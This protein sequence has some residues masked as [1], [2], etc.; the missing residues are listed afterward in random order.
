MK[1]G[2]YLFILLA[3]AAMSC[4]VAC[5][6]DDDEVES[7]SSSSDSTTSTDSDGNTVINGTTILSSSTAYGLV[8]NSS[9]GA[10]IAGVPVTDG[11]NFTTTDDN[12]VY[13]F[14]AYRLAR[15]I[16]ITVP[17]EYE[18]PL[19]SSTGLP[20]FY[21]S[22]SIS[23]SGFRS[24]F[25]LTPLSGG[26]EDEFTLVMIGDPQCQSDS[27]VTRWTTETIPDMHNTL[28]GYSHIYAFT[29]GDITFDNTSQWDPM[30]ESMYNFTLSSGETLPIFNC[31]GNH[32]HDASETTWYYAQDNFIDHFGPFD[33]SLNRGNVHIIVMENVY[34]TESTGS[35]WNY[36]AGFTDNQYKWL[37]ADLDLV[38]D[39]E[40]KMVIFCAHIPFRGGGDSES[41]ASVNTD[42]YY[43]EVLSL[44]TDFNEA[45]IMIGHTHYTQ[46]YL[47]TGYKT[48]NGNAIYEHVHGA[49][50]GAWWYSNVSVTGAPNGYTIYTVSGNTISEWTEHG[51][52]LDD[53]YQMRVY[54]GDKIWGS[55]GKYSLN[56]YTA[57]QTAGTASITVKGNSTLKNCFVAE[58]F[59]D[60]D[61]FWSVELWQDGSKVGDFTRLANGKCTNVPL[62][63]YH[64]NELGKNTSTW[65]ST[66]ASH[67]W[68][69]KPSS[70]SPSSESNWEV[71]A[72][73]TFPSSSV[74]K[75]YTCSQ[76]TTSYSEFGTD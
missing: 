75:T 37:C 72:T 56:W 53:S 48:K 19:D 63:S 4:M 71:R 40:D 43:A 46:N 64:F 55:D 36:E 62:A 76:F 61:T 59:N 21:S 65:S 22:G 42:K 60:D 47:H 66:T 67:Y 6:S 15:N 54:D 1:T 32:D 74:T 58:V 28:D 45:H 26:A 23:S 38:E 13:Q 73:Q 25:A 17:S 49:A 44:L 35:T 12:G 20:K 14:S 70:K 34:G 16:Y 11:Y 39:K 52:G 2:K 51:T 33:Y 7:S 18:I 29:L 5:S 50:C 30:A 10:G 57:S 68:Y 41:S 69:Y 9:T 27:N 8:Y 31:I 24:D 3:L